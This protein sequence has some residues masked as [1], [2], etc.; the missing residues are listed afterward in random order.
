MKL[1]APDNYLIHLSRYIHLNPAL[2]NLAPSPEDWIFSSY[3]DFIGLRSGKLPEPN[4]ILSYFDS[5]EAY[6]KFVLDFTVDELNEIRPFL[7]E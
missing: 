6:K 1:V 5:V 4:I 3:R 2:S 7:D